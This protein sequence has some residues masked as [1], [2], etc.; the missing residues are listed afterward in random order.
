M[1]TAAGG[2]WAGRTRS[3][4]GPD[5][6]AVAAS[7]RCPRA[8]PDRQPIVSPR[9]WTA[10]HLIAL[11]ELVCGARRGGLPDRRRDRGERYRRAVGGGRAVPVRRRGGR[12]GGPARRGAAAR[13]SRVGAAPRPLARG[14]AGAGQ[15]RVRAGRGRCVRP[16][17]AGAAAAQR[18][19][20]RR[21]RAG[22]VPL[23]GDPPGPGPAGGRLP[24]ARPCA[25]PGRARARVV[26][27][28]RRGRR[29]GR[30]ADAVDLVGPRRRPDLPVPGPGRRGGR[31]R[32]G[33]PADRRAPRAGALRRR[34]AP[35]PRCTLLVGR[36]AASPT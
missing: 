23:R 18:G 15:G 12:G 34:G 33:R 7:L 13:A 11:V 22:G 24:R 16:P 14:T 28:P 2:W 4:S 20:R 10:G 8:A 5:A 36:P 6:P 21:R 17:R 19:G 30:V 26:P 9:R 31:A 27:R 1:S 3:C 29:A 25:R 32:P 35:E